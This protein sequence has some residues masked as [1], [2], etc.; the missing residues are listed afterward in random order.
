MKKAFILSLIIIFAFATG[1]MGCDK[2]KRY[3]VNPETTQVVDN[4]QANEN[5]SRIAALEQ[6]LASMGYELDKLEEQ[7]G[8]IAECCSTLSGLGSTVE[9]LNNSVAN[10]NSRLAVL[11]NNV[12]D[13]KKDESGDIVIEGRNLRVRDG[14][15]GEI[16]PGVGNI[17]V[18]RDDRDRYTDFYN[19]PPVRDGS[20]NVVVGGSNE[21]RSN[22]GLCVGMLNQLNG[23]YGCVLGCENEITGQFG[24]VT[25]GTL[26]KASGQ[27]SSVSGG[28]NRCANGQYDWRGGKYFADN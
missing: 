24:T 2:K 6:L 3:Y 4:T 28:R 7:L 22:G 21:Y 8:T 27:F 23:D 9:N 1:F 18:G 11:E 15:E 26:N 20:N 5:S 13:I 12:G 10:I 14:S 16:V 25:G 17:L 19:T